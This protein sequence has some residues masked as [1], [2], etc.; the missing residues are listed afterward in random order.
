MPPPGLG[1]P[2]PPMMPMRAR[3]GGVNDASETHGKDLAI[4]MKAGSSS[5]EGRIE[6]SKM[7]IP[8][9]AAAGD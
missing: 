8:D 9:E 3:G 7:K 1:G 2:R 4:H 6:K 5:G